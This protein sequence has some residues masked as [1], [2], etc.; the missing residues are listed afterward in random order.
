MRCC[1]CKRNIAAGVDAQKMIV[2]YTQPDGSTKIF[3]YMMSDGPL[4]AATG[5]LLRAWHFRHYHIQRKREQRGDAVN[6]RIL[7]GVPTGYDIGALVLTREQAAELGLSPE[8]ARGT[9][10][11]SQRLEELQALANRVGKSIGDGEV[12]E[13]FRAEEHDGPY[14]HSHHL[15]LEIYQLLAHLRYAHGLDE[16]QR[17]SAPAHTLH[18]ELHARAALAATDAARRADPGH[19]DPPERDWR[20]QTVI[21]V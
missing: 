20:E 6:G 1:S 3:G 9:A 17:S 4:S 18:D 8:Q 15:P 5:Q 16:T 10:Y 2:E 13:A 14:R 19:V 12:L 21:D 7:T 11:L